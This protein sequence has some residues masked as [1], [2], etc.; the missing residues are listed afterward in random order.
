MESRRI[1]LRGAYNVRDLGGLVTRGGARVRAGYLFRAD[2]LHRLDTSDVEALVSLGVRKIFDLRS[3]EEVRKEASIVLPGAETLH[4]PLV[5]VS[6]SPFDPEVDWRRID[7]SDRYLEMLASGADAIRA[8]VY[9]A[10]DGAPILFHCTAGKD[11]TGVVAAILLRSLDVDDEEIVADYVLSETHLRAFLDG[12]RG[13]LVARRMPRDAIDYLT[14][15][16]PARMRRT[17]H[18]L[19]RRWGSTAGYLRWIGVDDDAVERLKLNL[20]D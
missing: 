1:A 15:S 9:A 10:A 3:D 18:E 13:Q 7:L 14:S 11:R 16:P 2:A 17:L 4:V 5:A 20:L 19:D 12:L 8:V 6:L